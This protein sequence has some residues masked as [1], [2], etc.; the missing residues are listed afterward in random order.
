MGTVRQE[1]PRPAPHRLA[2]RWGDATAVSTIVAA[3]LL[4]DDGSFP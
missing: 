1:R 3:G 4:I 2:A